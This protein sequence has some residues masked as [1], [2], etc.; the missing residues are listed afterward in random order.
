MERE[1]RPLEAILSLEDK[2]KTVTKSN[3]EEFERLMENWSSADFNKLME[4]AISIRIIN[5]VSCG[6]EVRENRS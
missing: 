5:T 6:L 4:R 1:V 2:E 3:Y